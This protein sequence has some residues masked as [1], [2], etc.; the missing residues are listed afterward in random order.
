M[1]MSAFPG[2]MAPQLIPSLPRQPSG[3]TLMTSSAVVTPGG[4][5]HRARHPQRLHAVLVRLLA[6][7]AVVGV[8]HDQP[9]QR[10][11]HQHDLVEADAAEVA[12]HPALEAADRRHHLLR[13]CR[14]RHGAVIARQVSSSGGSAGFLQCGH[15]VRTSRCAITPSSVDCDQVRRHAEVEQPRHRGRRVVRVQRRQHEVA[16]QRRLH[17]HVGGVAVADLADHDDVRILPQQRAHAGREI[18]ADARLHLH[19]V[20]RG[21]DHLDRVLD[22]ADV[23]LGRRE[24]LQRR[25]QRRRLARAGRPGDQDDAVRL[26]DHLLP[27]VAVVGG[28][29][30]VGEVA[31]QHVGREDPHHDL[32]A[33]RRRHRRD[34]QL[35]LLARPATPS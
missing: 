29:A 11:R 1:R 15:S 31:H 8:V 34:A 10:R 2:G 16:G 12:G 23:D 21:L 20:E 27:A 9:A 33:E 6:D 14:P 30:Q 22:R 7:R 4:D 26:V 5:L 28:E 24:L 25:V 18:D 35:D 32:L 19:L 17:R 13:A 3:A